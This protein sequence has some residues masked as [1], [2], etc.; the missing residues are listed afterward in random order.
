MSYRDLESW[1]Y[2]ETNFS[3]WYISPSHT[4][5]IMKNPYEDNA[6]CWFWRVYDDGLPQLEDEELLYDET[7]NHDIGF[8]ATAFEAYQD[9]C[10]KGMERADRQFL[11]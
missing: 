9:I 1:E 7:W 8:F 3:T 5:L 4:I 11:S 6:L 2:F 10:A